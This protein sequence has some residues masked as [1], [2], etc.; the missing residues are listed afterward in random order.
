M[1][2]V[3]PSVPARARLATVSLP[4]S[5]SVAPL[6]TPTA[7]LSA[8]RLAAARLS[9]PLLTVTVA[10]ALVAAKP[11]LPVLMSTPVPN[12]ALALPPFSA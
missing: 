6:A 7:A 12:A 5:A 10:A 9:V 3:R 1:P 8:S 11:L 4:L 2:G